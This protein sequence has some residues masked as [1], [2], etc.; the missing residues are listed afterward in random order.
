[1]QGRKGRPLRVQV[2][3]EPADPI[4][5][6]QG[7]RLRLLHTE[8]EEEEGGE[9][10]YDDIGE[11]IGT[12]GGAFG[13]YE[14]GRIRI[15]YELLAPLSRYYGVSILYLL[16]LSD[17]VFARQDEPLSD[18]ARLICEL[19]NKMSPEVQELM[20]TWTMAQYKLDQQRQAARGA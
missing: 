15:P 14:R 5:A 11:A 7:A 9:I 16:G 4:A 17:D 13:H 8:K 12:T 6:R 18:R 10:T 2:E 20:V 19:T 1:M 3:E